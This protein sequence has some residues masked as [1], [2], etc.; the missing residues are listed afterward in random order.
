MTAP[1]RERLQD[2]PVM[3]ARRERVFMY[4]RMGRGGMSED[5]I[6]R[7]RAH[8]REKKQIY[9]SMHVWY[10]L[11]AS[12]LHLHASL[13]VKHTRRQ[14]INAHRP[15]SHPAWPLFP[16]CRSVQAKICTPSS[17]YAELCW[18][19]DMHAYQSLVDGVRKPAGG[20]SSRPSPDC[21]RS[22]RVQSCNWVESLHLLDLG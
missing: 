22:T 16:R 8:L 13:K 20:G 2:Q 18:H 3:E 5:I 21:R 11:F 10:L 17:L 19:R 1:K 7:G 4:W 6:S 12:S 15:P 9:A 14:S